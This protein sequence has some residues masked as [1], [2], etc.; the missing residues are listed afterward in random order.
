MCKIR[1]VILDKEKNVEKDYTREI[2]NVEINIIDRPSFCVYTKCNED[3]FS[4]LH[5][6]FSNL[7]EKYV[8]AKSSDNGISGDFGSVSGCLYK[9]LFKLSQYNNKEITSLH[10][11]IKENSNSV[12]FQSNVKNFLN[13]AKAIILDINEL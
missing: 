7:E 12:R 10:K 4:S 9:V 2:E 6:K 5:F 13:L 11:K 3:G 8:S 1:I